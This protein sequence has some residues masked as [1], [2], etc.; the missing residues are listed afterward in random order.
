MYIIDFNTKLKNMKYYKS[1]VNNYWVSKIKCLYWYN[2]K[3]YWISESELIYWKEITNWNSNNTLYYNIWINK[4]DIGESNSIPLVSEK[5][6]NILENYW[7]NNIKQKVQFLP[8][9]LFDIE[10]KTI[11]IRWY[12][13][14]NI[15]NVLENVIDKQKSIYD[16]WPNSLILKSNELIGEDILRIDTICDFEF[17]LSEKLKNHLEKQELNLHMLYD[18][19][20]T[21][22][23]EE[24]EF[25][26]KYYKENWIKL[27]LLTRWLFYWKKTPDIDRE[28]GFGED[29][30]WLEKV[31]KYIK[32]NNDSWINKFIESN[33]SNENKKRLNNVLT[34]KKIIKYRWWLE[35]IEI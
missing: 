31:L 9:R 1:R 24:E 17:V 28:Y 3:L 13:L 16:D 30:K 27:W 14:M 34:W 35:K 33:F 12:Y 2:P 5:V 21:E 18:E 4:L 11:E 8:V 19:I 7:I 15:L 26:N 32:T 25:Y 22:S 6:K 10:T 29:P 20:Y 23:V